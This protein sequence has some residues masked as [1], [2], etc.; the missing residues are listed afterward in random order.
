MASLVAKQNFEI[1]AGDACEIIL[2]FKD[3]V[4]AP[5]T[6]I[7]KATITLR[8]H[9]GAAITI[10]KVATL[11]APN[12]KMTFTF[13]GVETAALVPTTTAAIPEVVYVHDVEVELSVGLSPVTIIRGNVTATGDITR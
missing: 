3:S 2:V 11:D 6:T 8:T 5:I 7:T 9:Y 13:T 1:Y 10:Q 4:G 12:G